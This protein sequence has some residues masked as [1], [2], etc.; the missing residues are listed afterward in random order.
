MIPGRW[1][2]WH[3][4]W[5]PIEIFVVEAVVV[6]TCIGPGLYMREPISLDDR[7]ALLEAWLFLLGLEHLGDRGGRGAG[8]AHRLGGSAASP[9]VC[10]SNAPQVQHRCNTGPGQTVVLHGACPP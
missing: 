8:V 5:E 7:G 3:A 4:G 1:G 9:T 10:N 6:V 2:V